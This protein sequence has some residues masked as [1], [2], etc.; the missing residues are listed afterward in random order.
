MQQNTFSHIRERDATQ[1]DQRS[2]HVALR[3]CFQYQA[4]WICRLC[5][6]LVGGDGAEEQLVQWEGAH[7]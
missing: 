4:I 7:G 1:D 2:D 5:D 3:P 6:R